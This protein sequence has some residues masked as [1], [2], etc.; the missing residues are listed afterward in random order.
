MAEN[1]Q[2]RADAVRTGM[3]AFLREVVAGIEDRSLHPQTLG[4]ASNNPHN[5]H[6]ITVTIELLAREADVA[7]TTGDAPAPVTI[8]PKQQ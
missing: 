4:V 2:T 8:V 6:I 1:E 5:P 3:V 7:L